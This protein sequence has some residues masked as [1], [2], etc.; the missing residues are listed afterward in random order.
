MNDNMN[1]IMSKLSDTLKTNSGSK[2]MNK[3]QM[4]TLTRFNSLLDKS[5]E[6][7]LCGPICQKE[8]KSKELEQKYLDSKTNLQ[9]APEQLRLA[10]KNYYVY[11]GGDSKYNE[12]IEEQ[13][14]EKA[15]IIGDALKVAFSDEIKRAK[16]LNES[17]NG[18]LI[19][20]AHIIDLYK[21]YL[22]KNREL[23]RNIKIGVN[24]VL[25]NDRKTYYEDQENDSLRWWNIFYICIYVIL[26]IG[27]II[28]CL[29]SPSTLTTFYKIL[30]LVLLIVYPFL[31]N[32]LLYWMI[33][34]IQNFTAMLPKNAYLDP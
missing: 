10:T 21:E 9:T 23:E 3:N 26:V 22:K 29:I 14:K 19:N 24:D 34:K 8:K 13:L 1:D 17:Y 6:A 16:E 20:S 5:S 27:F 11:T 2:D 25:T 4:D 12:I 18:A 33:G 28:A 7:M 30:I 15:K 31:A 32:P